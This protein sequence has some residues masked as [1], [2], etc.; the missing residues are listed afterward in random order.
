MPVSLYVHGCY[1][2]STECMKK[3]GQWLRT[4][5]ALAVDQSA[6]SATKGLKFEHAS[7]AELGAPH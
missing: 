3:R 2:L 5:K 7:L 6:V 1:Q 4:G